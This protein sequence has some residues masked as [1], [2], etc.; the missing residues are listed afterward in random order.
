MLGAIAAGGSLAWPLSSRAAGDDLYFEARRD[1]RPIG[2]HA[3]RFSEEEGRLIV[4]IEI[5][6]TLTFAFIPVYRYRHQ[7]REVWAGDTLIRLDAKTDD[8]GVRSWV[9]ARADGG[10]LLVDGS[11]GRSEMPHETFPASYWHRDTVSQEAWLDIRSGHLVRSKVEAMPA[12]P[13]FAAGRTVQ[14]E[15]YRLTG[16]IAC[17]LWYHEGRWSKHR[18]VASEGSTVEYVLLAASPSAP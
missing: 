3:V 16:A 18:F 11:A 15:H 17:D 8:D 5:S 14:A 9:S 12:E 10:R 13:I 2:H 4:D 1:G 7:N 6:L